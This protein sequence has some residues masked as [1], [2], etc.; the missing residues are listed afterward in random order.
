MRKF[1]RF[2]LIWILAVMIA[3]GVSYGVLYNKIAP[4]YESTSKLYVI[5][6]KDSEQALRAGSGGLKEDFSIIFKSEIVISEAKSIA[7]NSE[8][9]ASYLTVSSPA[10]SNVIE[11]TVR[12]PDQ[13]TAKQYVDA[14]ARSA[15]S[16]AKKVIPVEEIS[17]LQ[18]GTSTGVA[19]KPDL[20]K[21]TAYITAAAAAVIFVIEFIIALIMTAFGK[22]KDDDEDEYERYYRQEP[23]RLAQKQE[24]A[25]KPSE[26]EDILIWGDD[27]DAGNK[28]AEAKDGAEKAAQH[29]ATQAAKA[30]EAAKAAKEAQAAL[31]EAYNRIQ[32]AKRLEETDDIEL[33]EHDDT[34]AE[35]EHTQEPQAENQPEQEPQQKEE[36]EDDSLELEMEDA[37]EEE[38]KEQLVEAS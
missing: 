16:N 32:E 24:R 5:P 25:P 34:A 7:G 18:E 35:A 33:V 31:E 12:N 4:V 15:C 29:A 22:K 11:L 23:L 13:N 19:I 28:A 38:E 3:G 1:A 6:G 26:D 8:D 27:A 30:E 36:P 21:Y 10:D 17:V 2:A 20:I 9:L 37:L 14:I